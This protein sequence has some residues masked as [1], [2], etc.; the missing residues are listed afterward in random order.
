MN[1]NQDIFNN[2]PQMNNINTPNGLPTLSPNNMSMES[3]QPLNVI[4]QS[5][6][7]NNQDDTTHRFD[8]EFIKTAFSSNPQPVAPVTPTQ[9]TFINSSVDNSINEPVNTNMVN[10]SNNNNIIDTP[11][12]TSVN[13]NP[14]NNPV[15]TPIANPI[16]DV[17]EPPIV[18]DFEEALPSSNQVQNKFI[19]N[20]RENT[21]TSLNNLNIDDNYNSMPKVDYSQEPQVQENLK[22]KNTITITSEGKV[23]IIIIVVLLLFTFIMPYIFDMFRNLN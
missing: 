20:N 2:D 18:N 11:I 1:N 10:N 13:N 5:M 16:P 17:T 21:N 22:K 23:F 6:P 12:N 4:P 15:N 14:I 8:Q 3:P 7:I 19:N 9:N